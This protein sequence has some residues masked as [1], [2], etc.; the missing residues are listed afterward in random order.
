MTEIHYA[1]TLEDADT[2]SPPSFGITYGNAINRFDV[3][4]IT[5]GKIEKLHLQFLDDSELFTETIERCITEWATRLVEVPID[6]A[7]APNG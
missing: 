6:P 7:Y 5:A 3:V 2:F 1:T 4:N